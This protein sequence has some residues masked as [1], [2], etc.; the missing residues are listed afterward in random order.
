MHALRPNKFHTRCLDWSLDAESVLSIEQ[1]SFAKPWN[2]AKFEEFLSDTCA[3]GL[4]A[5][6]DT[7]IMGYVLYK[8]C[9]SYLY[10]AHG[11]VDQPFRALGV[12]R[13]GFSILGNEIAAALPL[14][15]HVRCG[16]VQA[17]CLYRNLGFVTTA[18][19]K[20]HYCDGDD[21]FFMQFDGAT[22]GDT[23]YQGS[24]H[25]S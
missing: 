3:G 5:H 20:G 6:N 8:R 17:Q 10:I 15:L 2:R 18:T 16:N 19:I 21:A 25:L 23:S 12:G 22:N 7:Q 9:P 4:V 13:A 11:A 24:A 14:A 1:R